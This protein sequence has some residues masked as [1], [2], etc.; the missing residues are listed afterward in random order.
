MY[1]KLFIYLNMF[2]FAMLFQG[3][4]GGGGSSG[5]GTQPP[6]TF[7]AYT[8]LSW[9]SPNPNISRIKKAKS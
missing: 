3:C 9:I 8:D 7:T 1:H 4:G 6:A 2:I 5:G